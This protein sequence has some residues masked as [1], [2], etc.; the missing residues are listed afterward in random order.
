MPIKKVAEM[1]LTDIVNEM[2]KLS[3][4]A[5]KEYKWLHKNRRYTA[6]LNE[7]YRRAME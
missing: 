6:L 5:Y 2:S 7:R 3:E 1:S 4:K